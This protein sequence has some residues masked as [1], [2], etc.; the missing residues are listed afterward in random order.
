MMAGWR[1]KRFIRVFLLLLAAGPVSAAPVKAVDDG[2]RAVGLSA[3]AKRIVSLA[4]HATEMVF[5][6]GA[7][8]RLVGVTS[9][10][11]Y[12]EPARKIPRVG[13]YGK[14]DAERILALQPDL[15][16]GWQSG[17]SVA[18]LAGLERLGIPVFLTE[19]RRLEDVPRLIES[20]GEL[21]GTR[22]VAA[23]AAARFRAELAELRRRY[24]GRQPVRVFYEIWHQPLITVNGAHLI[25]DVIGLCGG[26]NV[27]AS[28]GS[29]TLTIAAENVLAEDPEAIVASGPLEGWRR[30]PRLAAVRN[31]HLFFIRPDLIQ[32]Q[33]PRILDGAR[34]MCE[35]LE[36][37]R[38][39]LDQRRPD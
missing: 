13:S 10:S 7:G 22:Q 26:R 1:A 19:P 16:I 11:D 35:Q 9:F 30:Y 25:S 5:A 38:R 37:V 21:A 2:G 12:P 33:S 28:A 23:E 4:P 14:I 34:Q 6:A 27:F 32:R 31:A 17:N 15:V 24:G 36:Q 8:D 3:P 39:G 29:L 18:D 20:I